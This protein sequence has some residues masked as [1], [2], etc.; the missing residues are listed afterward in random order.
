[1]FTVRYTAR[2]FAVL[3]FDDVTTRLKVDHAI[4]LKFSLAAYARVNHIYNL[5]RP[6]RPRNGKLSAT[7]RMVCRAASIPA[8]ENG[9]SV[10]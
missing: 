4:Y 1:M 3:L 5:F 6:R 8:H 7:L 2:D 9:V 10:S